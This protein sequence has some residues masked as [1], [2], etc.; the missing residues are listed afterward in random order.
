MSRSPSPVETL[1]PYAAIASNRRKTAG[2]VISFIL[3]IGVAVWAV[4]IIIGL[5]PDAAGVMAG[6]ATL[7]S[8]F[9]AFIAYRSGDSIVLGIA[10]ARPASRE[11]YPQLFRTVENLCIGAGMPVPRVYVIMDGAMNAF[12][13]GRDPA[14]ATIAVTTGLLEKMEPLELEG[15]IAHELSHVRNLDIRLMM[16]TAV[17]VGLIAIV[18]DIALR[19]TW[20]GAGSRGRYKGKGEGGGAVVLLVVAVIALV[21]AP[22]IGKLIQMSLSRQREYLADA[23]GALLTRY[24]EGLAS[25]LE[26]I[27]HDTDPLDEATKG[28]AHMYIVN[29]LAA[30]SSGLN[31]MFSSHPSIEDRIERLRNMMGVTIRGE[32]S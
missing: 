4:G 28:T 7:I 24:P 26:K 19:S 14:H 32:K 22:I 17:L 18:A 21:L 15:V 30:H 5:P 12:A 2:L 3:V 29:P 10:E 25:A 11:A 27:S 20:Y 9:V 1:N 8:L 6:V 16:M 13:T 23:S 31:N